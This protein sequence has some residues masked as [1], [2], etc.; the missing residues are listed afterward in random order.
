MKLPWS[1]SMAVLTA[2]VANAR[3]D[4]FIP[5][6]SRNPVPRRS[7]PERARYLASDLLQPLAITPAHRYRSIE[8]GTL[9]DR[10]GVS[11]KAPAT[12]SP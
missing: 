12:Q 7:G 10:S 8:S 9:G 2:G 6:H 4:G 1:N 3:R 5:E 11:D